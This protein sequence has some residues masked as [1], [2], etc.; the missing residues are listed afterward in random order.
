MEKLLIFCFI[1]LFLSSCTIPARFFS[2]KGFTYKFKN[3]YTGLDS[4][5]NIDDY[6]QPI[7][8]GADDV[9]RY[10]ETIMFFNNGLVCSSIITNPTNDS[11]KKKV[12]LKEWGSYIISGDT[13]KVQ[14]IM[15]LGLVTDR[16]VNS[17]V[18]KIKSHDRIVLLDSTYKSDQ[19]EYNYVKLDNYL[20][21][22]DCWL[23]KKMV[24]GER[25]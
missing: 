3:E 5:L 4:L 24:L 8:L 23:L 18:Y 1:L 12:E 22:S 17:F 10:S 19:R 6:Y 7:D 13:I 9:S 20:D 16:V 25:I 21:Y 14:V 2:P 15:D 11:E